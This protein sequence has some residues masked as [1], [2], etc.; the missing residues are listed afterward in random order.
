MNDKTNQHPLQV[1]CNNEKGNDINRRIIIGA[2]AL[3]TLTAD[4]VSA[5]F[6]DPNSDYRPGGPAR[7]EGQSPSDKRLRLKESEH[8]EQG[9]ARLVKALGLSDAQQAKIERILQAERDNSAPLRQ[10]L[11]VNLKLLH[12]VELAEKFDEAV[13]RTIATSQ[14]QLFAEMIVVRARAQNQI[15]SLLAPEQL[16]IAE[17]LRPPRQILDQDGS[18]H[19]WTDVVR[20]IFAHLWRK[21]DMGRCSSAAAN[22][23]PPSIF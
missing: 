15:H 8:E 14:A 21:L 1:G 6:V 3:L 5:E 11:E 12:Q 7:K 4:G 18:D 19:P 10:K 9:F 20:D 13:V 23:I 2:S 17:K 22:D 16:A